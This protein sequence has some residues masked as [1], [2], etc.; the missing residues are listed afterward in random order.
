MGNKWKSTCKTYTNDQM[1]NNINMNVNL[2]GIE[3][4][5][6]NSVNDLHVTVKIH[7]KEK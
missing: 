5:T 1:V 7:V 4:A 2:D 6:C 3:H